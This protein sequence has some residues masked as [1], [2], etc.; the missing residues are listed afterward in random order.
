MRIKVVFA[1][2]EGGYPPEEIERR[3]DCLR[4]YASPGVA[5]DFDFLESGAG[6]VYKAGIEQADFDKITPAFIKKAV[7]ADRMGFDA[8]TLFGTA[9]AVLEEARSHVKIPVVGWG[10]ATYNIASLMTNK[11]A[12][13][14]YEESAISHNRKMAERY[15]VD[16][17]IT[18]FYSVKIPLSQMHEK[19]EELK[20]RLIETCK[21][22]VAE[23]AELIYPHGVSMIPLHY[24]PE[25][26]EKEIDVP[27][28]NA[29][30]IGIR[31]TELVASL[32]KR[33]S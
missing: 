26:I 3:K 24:R 13:I 10:K 25:E 23:G 21:R 7:E 30:E 33:N 22:A 32:R 15:R 19:R 16:H 17:L 9:D 18:S 1:S 31:M 20:G 2:H 29:M 28:L 8:F 4:Q 27:I 14:V 5:L 6:S 11:L 12:V